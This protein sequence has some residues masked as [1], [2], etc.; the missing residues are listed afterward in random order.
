MISCRDVTG[1]MVGLRGIIHSRKL[2]WFLAW[3][4][5]QIQVD[6]ILK[7]ELISTSYMD[8]WRCLD[9]YHCLS[10]NRE[11]FLNLDVGYRF[12]DDCFW[13]QTETTSRSAHDL[14]HMCADHS[15]LKNNIT[16]YIRVYI[17]IYTWMLVHVDSSRGTSQLWIISWFL[18]TTRSKPP[19]DLNIFLPTIVE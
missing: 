17:Y 10:M 6:K 9:E 19:I 14:N 11:S 1:M 7:D 5:N 16:I 13:H 8:I 3:R 12:I 4:M 2:Q 18:L 15:N